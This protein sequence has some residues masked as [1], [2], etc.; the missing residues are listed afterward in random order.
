MCQMLIS[1]SRQLSSAHHCSFVCQLRSCVSYAFANTL[2]SVQKA[3]PLEMFWLQG[4]VNVTI[5]RSRNGLSLNIN[6]L[7]GVLTM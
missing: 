5:Q 3:E 1:L 7:N 2:G 6:Q 4:E